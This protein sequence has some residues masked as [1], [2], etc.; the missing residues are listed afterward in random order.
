MAISASSA[1]VV[2]RWSAPTAA[3]FSPE[4]FAVAQQQAAPPVVDLAQ[5]IELRDPSSLLQLRLH[6]DELD[7]PRE[8]SVSSSPAAV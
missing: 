8:A 4:P 1:L 7:M 6:F 5:S 3:P 2:G